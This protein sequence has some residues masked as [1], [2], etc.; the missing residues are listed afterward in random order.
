[1][2]RIILFRPYCYPNG[3]GRINFQLENET[4]Y[5]HTADLPAHE[6]MALLLVFSLPNAAYD[7]INNK[8]SAN[9]GK[10]KPHRSDQGDNNSEDTVAPN[11]I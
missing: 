7:P 8:Y 4:T 11:F 2:K 10:P 9:V 1:M 3:S 6:L 5:R